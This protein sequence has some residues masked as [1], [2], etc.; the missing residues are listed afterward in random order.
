MKSKYL[1]SIFDPDQRNGYVVICKHHRSGRIYR[2]S[3]DGKW[4]ARTTQ[5]ICPGWRET[6][7]DGPTAADLEKHWQRF[8]EQE[9]RR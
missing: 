5:K 7:S 9:F 3:I 6:P 8:S 4:E 1:F 2:R